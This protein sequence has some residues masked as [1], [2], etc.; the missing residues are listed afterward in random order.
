MKTV[1][2]QLRVAA[3]SCEN[4]ACRCHPDKRRQ[5]PPLY[6]DHTRS[7]DVR[8]LAIYTEAVIEDDMLPQHVGRV[9]DREIKKRS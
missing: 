9:P 5:N 2:V 7:A 8:N 3:A 4:C 1:F 6:A